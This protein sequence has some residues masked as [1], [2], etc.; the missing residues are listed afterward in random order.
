MEGGLRT[1]L[2]PW[3]LTSHQ[4]LNARWS[5]GCVGLPAPQESYKAQ[6]TYMALFGVGHK[7]PGAVVCNLKL[8]PCPLVTMHIGDD[9]S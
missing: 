7:N 3:T 4:T 6:L 2:E 1:P 8:T 5:D 9:R